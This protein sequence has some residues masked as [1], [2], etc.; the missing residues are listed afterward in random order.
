MAKGSVNGKDPGV[1]WVFNDWHG[2]TSTMTRHLKGCYMD[3]LHAQFN[4]G[5]LSLDE[6]KTVL[7]SDFGKSWPALQ[8]KFVKDDNGFYYNSRLESEII[9]RKSFNDSRRDN[10]AGKHMG[11][12]LGNFSEEDINSVLDHLNL[13][14]RAKF[15]TSADS[16]R[17]HVRARMKEGFTVED[18]K[19]VIDHKVATWSKDEKMREYLRPQT[20]F[21]TNF[22]GYLNAAKRE[23]L[24]PTG[25]IEGILSID[26]RQDE[27]LKRKYNIQ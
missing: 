23:P 13:T 27:E 9:K 24:P 8:K 1:T 14:A 25:K 15:Q 16:N 21:S 12:G 3:L 22:E 7:G 18:C 2:G 17:K 4:N 6:I 11:N 10:A 26:S 20:L 19:T 5:H